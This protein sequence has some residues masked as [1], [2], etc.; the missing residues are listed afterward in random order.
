MAVRFQRELGQLIRSNDLNGASSGV[1]VMVLV[2]V[3]GLLFVC[4]H[5]P[6]DQTDPAAPSEVINEPTHRTTTEPLALER[7]GTEETPRP[8]G[9]RKQLENQ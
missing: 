3:A 4:S 1:A 5:D 8:N 6:F 7:V 9:R 2:V